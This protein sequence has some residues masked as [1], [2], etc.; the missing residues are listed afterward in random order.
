[1][2]QA[3]AQTRAK[4]AA[5]A[6]IEAA[7]AALAANT[8]QPDLT[9]AFSTDAD[10]RAAASGS[11]TGASSSV[12]HWT[13]TD[14][15]APGPTAAHPKINTNLMTAE[16]LMLLPYMTEDVADAILD[17]IDEDDDARPLGAEAGY[18]ATLR[19]PYEPRNAPIRSLQ[20]LELIAGVRPEY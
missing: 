16:S 10:L 19:N 3:V 12:F 7:I 17:W 14:P 6:G 18:Y 1:A 11:L 2:R 5:R 8:L 20:E 4:W 13:P 15:A 9:D